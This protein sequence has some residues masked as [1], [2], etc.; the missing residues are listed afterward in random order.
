MQWTTV[1]ILVI[2]TLFTFY[3]THN[4]F[5]WNRSRWHAINYLINDLN[6]SPKRIDGG[7]EFNAWNFY[8]PNYKKDNGKSWWWVQDDEF[9]I[10]FGKLNGYDVFKTY[11]YNSL[12]SKNK[13]YILKRISL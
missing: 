2:L 10:S 8:D 12:C 3:E 7:F 5:A 9:I 6:I 11:D 1:G 4:Y 13:L